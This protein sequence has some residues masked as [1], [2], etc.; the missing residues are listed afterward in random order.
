ME[1][2]F[3]RGRRRE[4]DV[5]RERSPRLSSPFR[6]LRLAFPSPKFSV[7]RCTNRQ[8]SG[9]RPE[10]D[11]GGRRRAAGRFFAAD[12]VV[13]QSVTSWPCRHFSRSSFICAGLPSCFV[14]GI[15]DS[16]TASIARAAER[17][18]GRTLLIDPLRGSSCLRG[19][20]SR[21]RI[22]GDLH[23]VSRAA[24]ERNEAEKWR[25]GAWTFISSLS[26]GNLDSRLTS[27]R[28]SRFH[29]T[30][31]LRGG[32]S[33]QIPIYPALMKEKRSERGALAIMIFIFKGAALAGKSRM[34]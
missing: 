18:D 16:A 33:I 14:R 4:R 34:S 22:R 30:I 32:G 19:E 25:E 26:R 21:A 29:V 17:R 27:S 9:G 3:A 24:K 12:F 31:P 11:I 8:A 2:I 6:A 1:S 13:N 15:S 5:S 20:N 10:T 23:E 28:L 7:A